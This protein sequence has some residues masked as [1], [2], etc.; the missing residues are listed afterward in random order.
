MVT[1][2]TRKGSAYETLKL[3]FYEDF[4]PKKGYPMRIPLIGNNITID[5]NTLYWDWNNIY[6]ENKEEAVL[7]VSSNIIF[8]EVNG[9]RRL[10]FPTK[11]VKKI[12]MQV[13]GGLFQKDE[14][15]EPYRLYFGAEEQDF[16]YCY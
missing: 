6:A 7:D 9:Q 11:G 15:T 16:R 3:L 10:S 8:V 5:F 2:K 12:N 4:K 14:Y 1:I 13:R